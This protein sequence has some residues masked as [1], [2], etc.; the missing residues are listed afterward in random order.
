MLRHAELLALLLA[1]AV[2]APAFAGDLAVIVHADRRA[3]LD[4]DDLAQIYLRK[5]RFWDDGGRIVPVN[6]ESSSAARAAF[7]RHVFGADA[8]QLVFYW[9]RQYYL[10]ILP[11]ATLASD[12]AVKRFVAREPLAIGYVDADAVDDS[13]RVILRIDDP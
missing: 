7:V 2:A 4:R 8:R 11:P 1:A 9:N 5:R 13:V 6:R 3:Q 12:E 10:G